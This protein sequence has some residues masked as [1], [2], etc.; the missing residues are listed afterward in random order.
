MAL[1]IARHNL[2]RVAFALGCMEKGINRGWS[3]SRIKA[4]AGILSVVVFNNSL[5]YPRLLFA[6]A[7][8]LNS[9]TVTP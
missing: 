8:T 2:G 1:S 4:D 6:L 7:E 5:W 3:A 9:T